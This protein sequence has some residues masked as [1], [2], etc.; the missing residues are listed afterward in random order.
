MIT[1]QHPHATRDRVPRRRSADGRVF[2][3]V[4]LTLGVG[5]FLEATGMWRMGWPTLLSFVLI[6][7]GLGML[8][9]ARGGRHKW[10]VALGALLT[11]ILLSNASVDLDFPGARGGVG[12]IVYRPISEETLRDRYDHRAGNMV[13]DLTRLRGLDDP[14]AIEVTQG[15][16]DLFVVVPEST[17]VFIRAAVKGGKLRLFG[18]EYDGWDV[19]QLYESPEDLGQS[20]YQL[21]IE[22][23]FGNIVVLAA[24][25]GVIDASGLSPNDLRTLKRLLDDDF[26][27]TGQPSETPAEGTFGPDPTNAPDEPDS[28][29]RPEDPESPTRPTSPT[30]RLR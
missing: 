12:N 19:T 10:P 21:D 28:P 8:A 9:T 26:T 16:G 25:E 11:V 3:F 7:L 30:L 14:E 24:D 6:A 5:W 18:E 1:H 20:A 23:G 17:P 13:L 22:I 29:E 4:V 27:F 2:G 15:A